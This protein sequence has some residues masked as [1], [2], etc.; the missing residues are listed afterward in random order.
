M[1]RLL[2]ASGNTISDCLGTT[3][4]QPRHYGGEPQWNRSA[5]DR[6]INIASAGQEAQLVLM[7]TQKAASGAL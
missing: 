1:F 4:E 7:M 6:D 2:A 3:T 5:Y